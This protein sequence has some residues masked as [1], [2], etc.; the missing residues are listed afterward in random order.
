MPDIPAKEIELIDIDDVLRD[1]HN[2]LNFVWNREHPNNKVTNS[3]LTWDLKSIYG[4]EI[5]EFYSEKHAEEIY[6]KALPLQGA[7]PFMYKLADLKIIYLISTQPNKK[8]E[9]YTRYWIR[10]KEIPFKELIF[11]HDK[12]IIKADY[13]LDDAVHNLERVAIM[14]NAKP[15]CFDRPWN[16]SWKGPRVKTHL[17][18]Y[19]IV[20]NHNN[21]HLI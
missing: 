7:I 20:L 17:E 18:F 2:F 12:S 14:K 15:V 13:L 3:P 21:Y 5:I 8:T 4:K 16:K 11:T 6:T 19:D 9:E 1:F 10:K